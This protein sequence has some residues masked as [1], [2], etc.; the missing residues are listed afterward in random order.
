MGST[1]Y[2]YGRATNPALSLPSKGRRTHNIEAEIH[3]QVM[4]EMRQKEEEDEIKRN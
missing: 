3:Q 4:E 1:N 2:T